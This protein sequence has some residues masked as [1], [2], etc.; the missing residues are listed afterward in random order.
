MNYKLLKGL[1]YIVLS[2]S[3][4]TSCQREEIG[5]PGETSNSPVFHFSAD[6]EG[7]NTKLEAGVDQKFMHTD[8]LV[9]QFNISS[10]V[11]HIGEESCNEICEGSFRFALRDYDT[12]DKTD[13]VKALPPS[14]FQFKNDLEVDAGEDVYRVNFNSI[15]NEDKPSFAWIFGDGT[16]TFTVADPIHI[17]KKPAEFVYPVFRNFINE[18][19]K[20]ELAWK[21]RQL[22]IVPDGVPVPGKVNAHMNFENLGDNKVRISMEIDGDGMDII[23]SIAWDVTKDPL[24]TT[25]GETIV[26]SNDHVIEL[27]ITEKTQI[28]AQPLFFNPSNTSIFSAVDL[29]TIISFDSD[30]ELEFTKVDYDYEVE[31]IEQGSRLALSTF[32][33]QYVDDS[34]KFYSSSQGEQ[35]DD[36]YFDVKSVEPYL[37]NAAG[38]KTMKLEVETSCRL[39]AD[40]GESI[41]L[42]NG[43]GVIAVAVPD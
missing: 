33:L 32:D 26:T 19:N 43:V 10:F 5:L 17:Y 27:E 6:L 13:L 12:Q 39:Y 8:W 36:A 14:S 21:S 41:L 7:V 37:A 16:T 40:D 15:F 25:T 23:P 3:I 42:T 20:L 2:I 4:L 24:N 1:F 30:G 31:E 28:G 22:T 11:G 34:G 38:Q 18:D 9:D 29:G 35:T